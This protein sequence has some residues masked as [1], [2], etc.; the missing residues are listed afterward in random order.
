MWALFLAFCF[1]LGGH[2][3]STR[4]WTPVSY[5]VELQSASQTEQNSHSISWSD[6]T[7][8]SRASNTSTSHQST[9]LEWELDLAAL[10]NLLSQ[11]PLVPL[12]HYSNARSQGVAVEVP[13][14]DGSIDTF[15]VLRKSCCDC[16]SLS[17]STLPV[18]TL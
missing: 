3:Q 16:I 1:V 14:P 18:H 5:E 9:I 15:Y 17:L 7:S 4:L 2:G 11:A 8:H 12:G 10:E 6:S 13:L